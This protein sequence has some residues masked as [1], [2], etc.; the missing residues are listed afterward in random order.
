[1]GAIKVFDGVSLKRKLSESHLQIAP[2][3]LAFSNEKK[4]EWKE[5]RTTIHSCIQ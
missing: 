3:E 5:K 2:S 4:T 1:M